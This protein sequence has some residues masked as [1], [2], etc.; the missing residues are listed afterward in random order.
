MIHFDLDGVIRNLGSLERKNTPCWKI[1]IDGED[2][3]EYI[4]NNL[5]ILKESPPTEYYKTIHSSSD[6]FSIITRQDWHWRPYTIEWMHKHFSDKKFKLN[7]V[8]SF[9]E[10]MSFLKEEDFIVEDFPYFKDYSKIVL[11]GWPYNENVKG[12]HI[13]ITNPKQLED[14][15][16]GK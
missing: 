2:F 6:S 15:L 4:N 10:K 7:F 12:E 3:C 8:G 13:R 14:F 9:E 1:K 5:H 16:K 11:I